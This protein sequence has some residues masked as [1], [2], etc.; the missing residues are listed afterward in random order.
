MTTSEM[1]IVNCVIFGSSASPS[2]SKTPANTGTMK[3]TMP[4]MTAAAKT[5]ITIG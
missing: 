1:P 3:A 2:S 5:K 4:S